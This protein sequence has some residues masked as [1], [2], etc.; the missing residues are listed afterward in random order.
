MYYQTTRNKCTGYVIL[1]VSRLVC[2]PI[3]GMQHNKLFLHWGLYNIMAQ[4]VFRNS[5]LDLPFK[6]FMT[7]NHV[8]II[9]T[10]FSHLLCSVFNSGQI[11]WNMWTSRIREILIGV[12]YFGTGN[13]CSVHFNFTLLRR[14]SY[15]YLFNTNLQAYTVRDLSMSQCRYQNHSLDRLCYFLHIIQIIACKN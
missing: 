4:I 8:I 11:T 9:L 15:H 1:V 12:G 2:A 3:N 6:Y 13:S 5:M 7:I 10:P 14:K